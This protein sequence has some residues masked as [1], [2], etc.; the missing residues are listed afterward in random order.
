MDQENEP[1]KTDEIIKNI[2][3]FKPDFICGY[4]HSSWF[5]LIR[6]ISQKP[7]KIYSPLL[8]TDQPGFIIDSTSWMKQI[9]PD[10]YLK[11]NNRKYLKQPKPYIA[12]FIA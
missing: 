10:I 3:N 4:I 11:L 2:I 12:K 9:L 6:D 8:D 7:I 1:L 5:K